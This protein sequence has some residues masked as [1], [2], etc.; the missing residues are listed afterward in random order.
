MLGGFKSALKSVMKKNKNARGS[1]AAQCLCDSSSPSSCSSVTILDGP[2]LCESFSPSSCS[3]RTVLNGPS[4]DLALKFV[5]S[6]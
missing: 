3:S 6:M 1:V 5:L 4:C 2:G